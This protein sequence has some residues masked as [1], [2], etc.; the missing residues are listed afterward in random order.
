MPL[1]IN[2]PLTPP[3]HVD[4]I[5]IQFGGT[6]NHSFCSDLIEPV[7]AIPW[8]L[9]NDARWSVP[10]TVVLKIGGSRNHGLRC[11]IRNGLS[12]TKSGRCDLDITIPSLFPF[13]GRRHTWTVTKLDT[14][15]FSGNS[16]SS[17][18]LNLFVVV[19]LITTVVVVAHPGFSSRD[20]N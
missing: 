12:K 16:V 20:S 8:R 4:S 3:V 19:V 7:F 6:Q 15:Q 17:C 11:L 9:R 10:T 18:T 14:S 13:L 1:G 2:V 5:L